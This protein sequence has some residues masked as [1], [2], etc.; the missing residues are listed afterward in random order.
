MNSEII[1]FL[2]SRLLKMEKKFLVIG[3]SDNIF[4]I[5]FFLSF[6]FTIVAYLDSL[7]PDIDPDLAFQVN[8]DP[9]P[10]LVL[11]PVPDPGF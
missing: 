11:D 2:G 1:F 8:P 9:V 5:P 4:L 3:S 6:V 7:N 10:V